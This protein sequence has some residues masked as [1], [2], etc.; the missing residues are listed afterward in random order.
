MKKLTQISIAVLTV[1]FIVSCG[2]SQKEGSAA[3]NDKKAALEKLKAE[4][5]KTDEEIQK[6]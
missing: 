1:L 3:I 5:T 4:R 2:N 6:L